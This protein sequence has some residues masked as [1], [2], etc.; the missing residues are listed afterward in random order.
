MFADFF[1]FGFSGYDG[2]RNGRIASLGADGIEF[3]MNF[4]AEEIEGAARRLRAD[5]VGM[6]FL[7]VGV[8]ASDFL[9][10]VA[11]IREKGNLL[12]QALIARVD[13]AIQFGESFF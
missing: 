8:K 4:L 2:L 6:E 13:R 11:T 10:D 5:E 9:A 1:E 12:E 7:E 3:A